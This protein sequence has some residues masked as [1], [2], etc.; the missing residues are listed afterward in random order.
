MTR[1]IL[2]RIAVA[3]LSVAGSLVALELG[4]RWF[5]WHQLAQIDAPGDAYHFNRRD[6][7]Y[8][9]RYLANA[10]VRD[11]R[12]DYNV[13]YTLNA[14]GLRG[15]SNDGPK[16]AGTRRLLML[17]DSFTFGIGVDDGKE[18]PALLQQAFDGVSLPVD[19]INAGVGSYSP[20]LHYL[21]LRDRYLAWEPDAV[22]LWIDFGDIHDDAVYERHLLHD[23]EG[24]VIACNP[25]YV[26]GR[27]DWIGALLLRSALMKYLHSK[28]VR[29]YEKIRILGV[30]SYLWAKIRGEDTKLKAVHMLGRRRARVDLVKYDRY[31]MIRGL[32]TQ[33]ELER[34][35]ARTGGY[36]LKIHEM[37]KERGIPLL[38][39]LYPYGTQ[40]GPAQWHDGRV[41]FMFEQGVTYDDPLPF[42]FIKAFGARHGIPVIDTHPSFAAAADEQL[43]LPLDGHFTD[44]GHRVVASHLLRDPVFLGVVDGLVGRRARST[45]LFEPPHASDPPSP[46]AQSR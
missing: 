37:L 32:A 17:G 12:P 40:V 9:H 18:F 39:G 20:I 21:T 45:A 15:S 46:V 35:W 11:Q 29:S 38:L 6:P 22:V 7:V 10:T 42:D 2:L 19:V 33:A 4:F 8:H 31:L 44:A 26:D 25:D 34:Y 13:A 14:V 41:Y 30:R 5:R 1:G 24:R 16:P 36:I 3:A 27:P 43:F 28:F 23:E